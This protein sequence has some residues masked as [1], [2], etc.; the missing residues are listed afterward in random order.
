MRAAGAV[1]GLA[2]ACACGR[3]GFEHTSAASDGG[4]TGN[5]DGD[6]AGGSPGETYYATGFDDCTGWVPSGAPSWECGDQTDDAFGPPSG[7]S[8]TSVFGTRLNANYDY[9]SQ[10]AYLDSPVV[11]I[12]AGARRPTLRFWMDLENE[13]ATTCGGGMCDAAGLSIAVD[14]GPF[15]P[16]AFGDAAMR[17]VPRLFPSIVFFP[18]PSWGPVQPAGEWDEVVI[19]L[20]R[21]TTPGLD[22]IGPGSRIQLRFDHFSDTGTVEPGW[23]LDDLSIVDAAPMPART[24]P[25]VTGFDDWDGWYRSATPLWEIGDQTN[26]A[27]GPPSGHSGT[28]VLGTAVNRTLDAVGF[29]LD[30]SDSFVTSPPI[31]LTGAARPHLRFWMDLETQAGA[32]GGNVQLAVN[33]GRFVPLAFQ[34]P[35]IAGPPHTHDGTLDPGATHDGVG[36]S[37]QIPAGDWVEVD[38]DLFALGAPVIVPGDVIEI[39]FAAHASSGSHAYAG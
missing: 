15:I 20:W 22:A 10:H 21:M 33:G 28:S 25:Y 11:A 27:A 34:D 38:I 13:T 18:N 35:A 23:Y 4:G 32:A 5:A 37:G 30:H 12:G 31:A 2:L 29:E 24:V 39:R 14:G 19:D 1:A 6:D 8:G 7:H 26:S 9:Y 3:V 17:G 16:I 36:W